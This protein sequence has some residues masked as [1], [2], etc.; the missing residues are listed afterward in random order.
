MDAPEVA[1]SGMSPAAH[2]RRARLELS[3]GHAEAAEKEFRARARSRPGNCR[4]TPGARRNL[5]PAG[6]MEDAVKE[7][8]A[9]SSTR[10]RRRSTC[11][12]KN[13]SDRKNQISRGRK[14]NT[15]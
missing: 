12:Q 8:Q 10:L 1:E 13:L 7:L 15:P 11:W 9:S 3:A 6:Q 2:I 14:W 4:G 5:S